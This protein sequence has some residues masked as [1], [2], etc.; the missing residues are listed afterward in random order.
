MP[1]F[2]LFPLHRPA[3]RLAY[4]TDLLA[5]L[6]ALR[7]ESLAHITALEETVRGWG[8]R[9]ASVEPRV[10]DMEVQATEFAR[11]AM[12]FEQRIAALDGER[13]V[14]TRL[15]RLEQQALALQAHIDALDATCQRLGNLLAA[16]SITEPPAPEASG[17]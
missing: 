7:T 8:N 16:H 14:L 10:A 9:V 2:K 1:E 13:P 4:R 5:G 15:D 12:A 11:Q 6:A 3:F 17:A